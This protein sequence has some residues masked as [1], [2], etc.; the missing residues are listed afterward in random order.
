MRNR[1]SR[2]PEALR[3]RPRRMSNVE[4]LVSLFVFSLA[5]GCGA[6]GEPTPPSPPIPVA[7]ADLTAQQAGD[8]VQLTFTLP[9]K[10]VSGERL[11]NPPAIE[12]LRGTLKPD[13]SP[14]AKSFRAIETIPGALI[15]EY[16]AADK[17]QVND[18]LSSDDL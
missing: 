8:A 5:A 16:R 11:T 15:G 3:I 13:G 18:R 2:K 14:D 1:I 10:T 9:I 7:I 12:I 4:I 6:P 17:V